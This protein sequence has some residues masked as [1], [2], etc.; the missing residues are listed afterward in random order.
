MNVEALAKVAEVFH[1]VDRL[2]SKMNAVFLQE[3]ERQKQQRAKGIRK[4]E[5]GQML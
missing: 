5:E 4:R 3:K 1:I 2:W